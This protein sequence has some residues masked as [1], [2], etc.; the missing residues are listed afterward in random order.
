MNSFLISKPKYELKYGRLS[1]PFT[2]KYSSLP[3]LVEGTKD[4]TSSAKTLSPK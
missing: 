1:T 3:A 2:F 4:I